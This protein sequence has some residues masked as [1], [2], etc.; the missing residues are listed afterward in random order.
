MSI[1]F[2][3]ILTRPAAP[4]DVVEVAADRTRHAY[5]MRVTDVIGHT[6]GA[7]V[8]GQVIS[9]HGRDLGEYKTFPLFAGIPYAVIERPGWKAQLREALIG[10]VGR[11]RAR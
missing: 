5:R 10:R 2:E 3:S 1:T 7:V 9:Q 6:A 11:H 8:I 4:G